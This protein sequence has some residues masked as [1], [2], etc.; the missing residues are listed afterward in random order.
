FAA[1]YLFS[2]PIEVVLDFLALAQT[3]A[4]VLV[5]QGLEA[6]TADTKGAVFGQAGDQHG[7]LEAQF[8]SV[9]LLLDETALGRA[10]D[11][12]L[13]EISGVTSRKGLQLETLCRQAEQ[14]THQQK[15]SM[16]EQFS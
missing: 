9:V 13:L 14:G 2:A 1:Q 11:R 3:A 10:A 16:H 6:V 4:A 8:P 15:G 12:D 5:G 7:S